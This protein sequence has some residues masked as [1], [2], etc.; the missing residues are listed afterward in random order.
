M[1]LLPLSLLITQISVKFLLKVKSVLFLQKLSSCKA[2][3][4]ILSL[5]WEHA[6][7]YVPSQL[8]PSFPKPLLKLHV[9]QPK[10]L[11]YDYLQLLAEAQTVSLV[12]T[13][14]NVSSVEQATKGQSTAKIWFKYRSGRITASKMKRM[15]QTNHSSPSHWL[16]KETCYPEVFQFTTVATEW[17]IR[18]EKAAR[19]M[20]KEIMVKEHDCFSVTESGLILNSDWPF[21]GPSPDGTVNCSCCGKGVIEIKCPYNHG[22]DDIE[23]VATD[24]RSCLKV[25]ANGI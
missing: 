1:L 25:S 21:L 9:Y 16:I 23:G 17:G 24:S 12:V 8:R 5:N 7:S 22:D 19:N 4:A 6:S 15:C 14:D 18:H 20:C 13:D 2:K 10:F 11:Q 3:P